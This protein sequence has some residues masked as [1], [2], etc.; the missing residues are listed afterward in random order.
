MRLSI[1]LAE[2]HTIV[3]EGLR[4]LLEKEGFDVVGVASD[5]RSAVDLARRFRPDIAILDISM[6]TLNGI[7]GARE[8]TRVS[9]DTRTIILTVH[10]EKQYVIEALR[11][12]V[13]GYLLKTKAASDL[14]Q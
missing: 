3:L 13:S 5:G 1:I 4:A 9:P 10:E 12:G 6:P 8:I 2:D 14:V 7:D 11:A